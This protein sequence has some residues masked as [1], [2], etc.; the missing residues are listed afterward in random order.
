MFEFTWDLA[1]ETDNSSRFLLKEVAESKFALHDSRMFV[2]FVVCCLTQ[3]FAH[4]VSFR[5]QQ[6]PIRLL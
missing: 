6:L 2:D 5:R 3:N 4:F 1:G